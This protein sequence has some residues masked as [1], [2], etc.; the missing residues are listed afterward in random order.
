[1]P[2]NFTPKQTGSPAQ[3]PASI[4][5]NSV[6]PKDL[7]AAPRQDSRQT[8]CGS[9]VR[10]ASLRQSTRISGAPMTRPSTL[11]IFALTLAGA[12]CSG[13]G[14]GAEIIRAQDM[15]RGIVTTRAQCAATPNTVW[16][17]AYGQDFC[18]RY[19]IS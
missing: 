12:L 2:I 18:V 19:Y 7:P 5:N 9:R 3:V 11:A 13:N 4:H 10:N 15:L 8:R 17:T 16:V 1:M 14:A 6:C